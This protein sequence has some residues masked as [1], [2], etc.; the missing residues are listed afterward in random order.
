MATSN[1]CDEEE[2][3][4]EPAKKTK[5]EKGGINGNAFRRIKNVKII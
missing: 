1:C 3:D 4:K 2:E 5:L